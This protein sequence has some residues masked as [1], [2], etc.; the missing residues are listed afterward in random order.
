MS[1]AWAAVTAVPRHS[2]GDDP[3]PVLLRGS[4][5]TR[6]LPGVEGLAEA[7]EWALA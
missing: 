1:Q 2:E 6:D 7:G 4:E 5:Q 3:G